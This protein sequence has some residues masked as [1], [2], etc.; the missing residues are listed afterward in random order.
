M[1][2]L[3]PETKALVRCYAILIRAGQAEIE[4]RRSSLELT[5]NETAPGA[6]TPDAE[7]DRK[8]LTESNIAA[9]S[10]A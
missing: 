4:R 2:D 10:I 8:S 3:S 7:G 6:G 1:P 9:P 5:D